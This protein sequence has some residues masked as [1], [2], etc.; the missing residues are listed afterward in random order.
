MAAK[1]VVPEI[2]IEELKGRLQGLKTRADSL[3]TKKDALIREGA[4]QDQ[5]RQQAE[6]ELAEL[7]YPQAEGMDLQGLAELAGTLTTDL[8]SALASRE[9]AVTDAEKLQGVAQGLE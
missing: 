4:T 7:G 9:T 2:N 5:R 8:Q 3:V 1:P 6:K